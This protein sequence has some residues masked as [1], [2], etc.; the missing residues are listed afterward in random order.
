MAET[1]DLGKLIFASVVATCRKVWALANGLLFEQITPGMQE[2]GSRM[3]ACRNSK[4]RVILAFIAGADWCA[5]MGDDALEKWPN[6]VFDPHGNYARLGHVIEIPQLSQGVLYEICSMHFMEDG[7]NIPQN[8]PK[9]LYR[10][11]GHE[12]DPL[13]RRQFNYEM[14]DL[15]GLESVD[16]WIDEHWK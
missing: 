13:L 5:A 1:S 14:R 7:A 3:T 10:L 16:G 12:P 2:S 4:I 15:P 6:D 8:W 11:L 9:T